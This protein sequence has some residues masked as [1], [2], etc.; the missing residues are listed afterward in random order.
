VIGY[1]LRRLLLSRVDPAEPDA[2]LVSFARGLALG[3]LAGA[4]IAGS[5]IWR[6]W[7]KD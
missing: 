7:L 5:G 3:A 4:A 2:R 6:R 1:L